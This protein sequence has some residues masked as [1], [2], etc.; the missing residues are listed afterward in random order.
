MTHFLMFCVYYLQRCY[1][2]HDTNT[3]IDEHVFQ[4]QHYSDDKQNE[5]KEKK[6]QNNCN[7]VNICF[8]LFS[9]AP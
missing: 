5:S 4:V 9:K 7:M 6:K 3:M 8:F 1:K 2:L